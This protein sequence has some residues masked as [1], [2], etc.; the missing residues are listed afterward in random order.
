MNSRPEH[1]HAL[2]TATA[3]IDIKGMHCASCVLNVE[4]ALNK[5]PGASA[6]SVNLVT[7]QAHVA[8][9]SDV[10]PAALIKAIEDAGYQATVPPSHLPEHDHME[11]QG[12]AD[13]AWISGLRR[14]FWVALIFSSIVMVIS[15]LMLLPD[16]QSLK[17]N[18]TNYLLLLLTL[19]VIFYS[20]LEFYRSAW[21]AARHLTT[22]MDTLIAVGTLTAFLYSAVVTIAPGRTGPHI[23][24]VYFD[25]AAMIITLLLLGRWLEARAK[26]RT[27]DAIRG[28]LDLSPKSAIRISE[29]G[30]EENILVSELNVGDLFVAKPGQTIATDGVV[31]FGESSVDQSMMTGESAPVSKDVGDFVFGATRVTSGLLRIKATKIGQETA[32]AA[33]VRSVREAQ[34]GKPAIQRLA[35]KVSAVFVPIVLGIGVTTLVGWFLL[36]PDLGIQFAIMNAVAVL[37]IACPCALGLATPT[38]ILVG[39]GKAAQLGILFRNVE[40][41]EKLS[42]LR[43]IVFDKTGTLTNG[44]ISVIDRFAVGSH[45]TDE[46][47]TIAAAL[48]KGSDHPIA[49]AIVRE[50][51]QIQL[52][53]ISKF[54]NKAGMGATAEINGQSAAIGN[55]RLMSELN[56]TVPA[57]LQEWL[58]QRNAEAKGVAI[59]SLDGIAIGALS[60]ADTLREDAGQV[61][62]Q[63]RTR[64]VEAV[65]ITGD[66][67]SVATEISRKLDIVKFFADALPTDKERI[68]RDLRTERGAIAMIGDGINDSPALAVADVGIAMFTGAD[69]AKDTAD[70]TLMSNHLQ[71]VLTAIDLSSATM[72]TIKQ[73]LFFAFFYNVIGIPVAAGLL[74]PWFGIQLDPMFAAAAMALSSISVVTNSLR[75]KKFH[76]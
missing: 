43:T 28:L 46:V 40:A 44:L 62:G 51:E 50:A 74:I 21:R 42:T 72:R 16:F 41:L 70:I 10:A 12:T 29:D 27:G 39:S 61:I 19:P 59:V 65:M 30:H 52:P 37:V 75:L 55:V 67:L 60:F 4:R 14:K 32:L 71:S 15:L 69:V 18:T 23:A 34:G 24:Q 64:G 38:A 25:S 56:V 5:V 57:Q 53:A 9:S 17:S 68:V 7:Q 73:N 2:P 36:R 22:N 26:E 76:A 6:A 66:N 13:A 3:T 45:S 58:D 11:H 31:V 49:M 20:G 8:I 47:L 54:Q 33:I 35:D 48:E 1:D 63:L